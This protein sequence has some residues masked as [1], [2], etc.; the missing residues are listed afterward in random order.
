MCV[1]KTCLCSNYST[2]LLEHERRHGRYINECAWPYFSKTSFMGTEIKFHIIF[3][4]HR[5][6]SLLSLTVN[7]LKMAET[8]LGSQII[9]KQRGGW[10]RPMGHSLPVPALGDESSARSIFQGHSG[11]LRRWLCGRSKPEPLLGWGVG[12]VTVTLPCLLGAPGPRTR[13]P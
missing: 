7:H 9:R 5:I 11:D 12:R 3:T 10:I 2:L 6:L 8:I 4:Y 1:R 13:H